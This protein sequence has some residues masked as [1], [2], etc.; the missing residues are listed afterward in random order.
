MHCLTKATWGTTFVFFCVGSLT[1]FVLFCHINFGTLTASVGFFRTKFGKSF[2][3]LVG[4]KNQKNLFRFS[5]H[6]RQFLA[7]LSEI[8]FQ[9]F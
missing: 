8:F 5:M 9:P 2:W 1:V 6:F 3:V 7:F 4:K